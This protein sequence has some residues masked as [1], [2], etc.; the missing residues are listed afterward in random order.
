MH[1]ITIDVEM[2]E[3]TVPIRITIQR[4]DIDFVFFSDPDPG[5]EAPEVEEPKTPLRAVADDAA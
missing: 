2:E 4:P 5:E 3:L 1:S